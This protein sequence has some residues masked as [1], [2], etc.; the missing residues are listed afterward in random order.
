MR[1]LA[2]STI[3]L[4]LFA[5]KLLKEFH[6]MT[7]RQLHYAI[8]SRSEIAYEND[9]ASYRKLS[10]VTTMSRRLDRMV[11]IRHAQRQRAYVIECMRKGFPPNFCSKEEAAKLIALDFKTIPGSWII[12]E[13]R[14]AETPYTF[15]DGLE[16]CDQVKNEFRRDYWQSQSNHVEVWSEKATIL[17]SI[18]SVA[19]EYGFTLRVC[20]GFGSTGMESVIGE[21]FERIHQNGKEIVIFYLGD[22]DPSGR[23]IEEDIHARCETASHTKFKMQRLAIHEEDIARFKLPPQKIKGTDSRAAGFKRKYGKRASTVE[24]D[25]LPI[26]ELRRRITKAV[27]KLIDFDLWN[28][29]KST[30]DAQ[31]T[32]IADFSE[33]LRN[34]PQMQR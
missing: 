29:E 3:V 6:P 32:C 33:T 28:Q 11:E 31:L 16:Y 7:L 27:T 23:V 13:T 34:L 24:L 10:A 4:A 14:E 30:E 20:H 9:K 18:R 15:R 19:D 17:A 22:H 21:E 1:G 2:Q 12:D 25:A 5:Y 26:A 8:F